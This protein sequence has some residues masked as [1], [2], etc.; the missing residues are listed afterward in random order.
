MTA[1][2]TMLDRVPVQRITTE[3]REIHFR[4]TALTLLA[5]LFWLLGWSVGKAFTAVWL[6]L[7]FVAVAVRIGW[8]DARPTSPRT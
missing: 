6:A 7:A 5:G 3:A 2:D 1:L 8:S 4:R